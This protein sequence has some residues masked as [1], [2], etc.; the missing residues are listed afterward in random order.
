M[1]SAPYRSGSPSP[2]PIILSSP[3]LAHQN[4][5]RSS[6]PYLALLPPEDKIP[7]LGELP[8]KQLPTPPP[9]TPARTMMGHRITLTTNP[10]YFDE[11]SEDSTRILFVLSYLCNE[12]GT[13]Y[14]ALRW[15]M[16]WKQRNFE[17][18]Q[19]LKA[20]V[21]TKD[22]LAELQRAFGDSNTE[23]VAAAQ[24][25]ALHQNNHSF[26][27]DISDFKMLAADAGYNVVTTTNN[28]GKYKKGDQDNILIKCLEC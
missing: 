13:S 16:N 3:D 4:Q 15:V 9:T 21:T 2:P 10:A 6:N 11:F 7:N 23:Q 8:S 24:L 17:R 25:M 26:A 14:A 19:G 28:Q 12:A 20:G 22:F 5:P 18:F 27:D 1:T